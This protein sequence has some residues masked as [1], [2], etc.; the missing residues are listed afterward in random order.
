M[1]FH[2]NPAPVSP[3]KPQ[4][5]LASAAIGVNGHIALG[6]GLGVDLTDDPKRAQDLLASAVKSTLNHQKVWEGSDLFFLPQTLTN[7]AKLW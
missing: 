5:R 4:Y 3:T 1:D 2:N 7:Q 6:V